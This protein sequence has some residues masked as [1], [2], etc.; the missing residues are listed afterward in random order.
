MLRPLLIIAFISVFN[1]AGAQ[2][3]NDDFK[4]DI[5]A[6]D[7]FEGTNLLINIRKRA[8]SIKIIYKL[9][10]S[11][12]Y[13][14]MFKDK[15]YNELSKYMAY[16]LNI[17]TGRDSM[18][19]IDHEL[20]SIN[21]KYTHYSIDSLLISTHFMPLYTKLLDEVVLTN[22]DS[23]ENKKKNVDRHVMDGVDFYFDIKIGDAERTLQ[24]QS[25]NQ[26]SHP[27]LYQL[28]EQTL[29]VYRKTKVNMFLSRGRTDHY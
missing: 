5:T 7:T 1:I 9:R 10:D 25:P 27:I 8:D 15:R 20:D 6:S 21:E 12:N 17:K 24:A 2:N 3:I 29:D 4:I 23:L 14:G 13:K 16:P 18:R 22:T 19:M 11:I 28:L 26:D